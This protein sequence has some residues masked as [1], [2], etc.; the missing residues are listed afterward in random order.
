MKI[1]KIWVTVGTDQLQAVDVSAAVNPCA[2]HV[3]ASVAPRRWLIGSQKTE[4]P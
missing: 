1:S 2:A 4:K 3:A